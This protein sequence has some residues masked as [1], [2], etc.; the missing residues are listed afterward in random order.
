MHN[1]EK[2]YPKENSFSK[3][4]K[5]I[6]NVQLLD[7]LKETI[8]LFGEIPVDMIFDSGYG[9]GHISDIIYKPNENILF[10]GEL[11]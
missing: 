9:I 11:E 4:N 3:S 5:S 10:I 6:T 1:R 2:V 8:V 7:I